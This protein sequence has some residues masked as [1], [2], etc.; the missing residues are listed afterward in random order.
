MIKITYEKILAE[1]K[2][3]EKR[4]KTAIT[5]TPSEEIVDYNAPTWVEKTRHYGRT[6]YC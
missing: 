5:S 4:K 2:N 1:Q 6:V 3:G